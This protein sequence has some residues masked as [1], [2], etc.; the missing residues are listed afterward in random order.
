M[1]HDD[2]GGGGGGGGGCSIKDVESADASSRTTNYGMQGHDS[3][4]ESGR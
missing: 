4:L 3:V 2:P 1:V